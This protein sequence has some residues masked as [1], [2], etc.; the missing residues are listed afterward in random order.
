LQQLPLIV[1]II[2]GY[3]KIDLQSFLEG[4]TSTIDDTD[5]FGRT[6]LH[7]SSSRGDTA[8]VR[9]LLAFGAAVSLPEQTGMT[10]LHV[11]DSEEIVNLLLRYGAR[12]DSRDHWDRTPLHW[13]CDR[14]KSQ[15]VVEALLKGGADVHAT[16]RNSSNIEVCALHMTTDFG[17]DDLVKCLLDFGASINAR[18]RPDGQTALSIAVSRDNP[19]IVDELLRRGAN[20]AEITSAGETILHNAA[21]C[22]SAETMRV[23]SSAKLSSICLRTC[24]SNGCTAMDAF[25]LRED[26]TE[27]LEVAFQE[28]VETI[29]QEYFQ[30]AMADEKKLNAYL[31]YSKIQQECHKDEISQLMEGCPGSFA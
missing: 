23:L 17:F 1:K 27:S 26:K 16:R 29:Q 3:A 19:L 25:T 21:K 15:E 12:I 28:L 7:W 18:T 14:G 8:S 6:A 2:L 22:C 24:D 20:A 30:D 11:A 13:A 31:G 5:T 9:T 4:S 10:P